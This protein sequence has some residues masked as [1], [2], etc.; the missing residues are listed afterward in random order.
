VSLVSDCL[1]W[2]AWSARCQFLESRDPVASL[3]IDLQYDAKRKA[4][5]NLHQVKIPKVF[6]LIEHQAT[7][8]GYGTAGALQ[9]TEEW[10]AND[11]AGHYII[12][13]LRITYPAPAPK[14]GPL[15]GEKNLEAWN[16]VWQL[17][18]LTNWANTPST[19][20]K[21]WRTKYPNQAAKIPEFMKGTIVVCKSL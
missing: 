13:F 1:R 11:W 19:K 8:K 16:R 2:P 18:R 7:R 4:P 9:A 10:T 17:V 3:P 6:D 15:P 20:P 12:S 14:W 5:W 21:F